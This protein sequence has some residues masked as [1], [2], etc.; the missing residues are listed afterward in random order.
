MD[1]SGRARLAAIGAAL[2]LA[3]CLAGCGGASSREPLIKDT[4]AILN[5]EADVLEKIHDRASAEAALPKLQGLVDRF[6][7]VKAEMEKMPKPS[8]EVLKELEDRYEGERM[9]AMQRLQTSAM[10]IRRVVG[11]DAW[12]KLNETMS[13]ADA[14]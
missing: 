2:A 3:A 7:A 14:R 5:E 9:N 1:R 11:G 6:L 12:N 13:K 10:R 8:T 4:L